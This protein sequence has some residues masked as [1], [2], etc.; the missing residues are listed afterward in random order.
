MD[1]FENLFITSSPNPFDMQIINLATALPKKEYSTD[2]LIRVFPCQLSKGVEQN[3]LN[4]GVSRRYL[5]NHVDAKRQF[6]N[7]EFIG[8]CTNACQKVIEKSNLSTN[9][10]GFL[11]ATYDACPFLSPGPGQ[12]LIREAG[13]SSYTKNANIQ[14]IA[15]TAF[16]KAL[17]LAE[18]YLATHQKDH[19]LLCISGVSSFWFQ[20]Q[21]RGID[22]VMEVSEIKRIR[23]EARMQVELR[24]W[25]ATMEFFLFGDGVAA[26]IVGRDG[27]GLSIKKNVEVTN[28]RK[29]DYLAGYAALSAV[30]EPFKFGFYSNL[31][32]EIPELGARYTTLALRKLLGNKAEDITGTAKKWAVHTGSEKILNRLAQ[33]HNITYEKIKESH[34]V[35]AECGNLSGAS[36]PFILGKIVSAGKLSRNDIVLMVG[37]G[38]GFSATATLMKYEN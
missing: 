8:L 29:E 22:S 7:A 18:N 5:V 38:W 36:L 19:V 21:V 1:F 26:A 11:I 31:S 27:V 14:G 10:I 9:D 4:L 28:I 23:D 13:L 24:K 32:R 37:Y 34:E 20:N 35:L 33:T 3:I 12:L 2:E 17:E 15:S 30:D 6:E 25:I 16:P